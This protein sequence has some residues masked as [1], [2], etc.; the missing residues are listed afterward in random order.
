METYIGNLGGIYTCT[1]HLLVYRLPGHC[2]RT[3][4]KYEEN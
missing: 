4:C 2:T 1:G 3:K